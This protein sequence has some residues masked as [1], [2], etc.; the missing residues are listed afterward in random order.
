MSIHPSNF[1]WNDSFARS[2]SSLATPGTVPARVRAEHRGQV[3]VLTEAGAVRAFVRGVLQHGLEA[4]AVGDWVVLRPSDDPAIPPI[5]EA[6]LPRHTRFVRKAAGRRS[7]P[8]VIAANIDTVFV[9]TSMNQELSPRRIERYLAAARAGG[10]QAVVVLTKSDQVDDVAAFVAQVPA[11]HVVAVSALAGDNLD[12]LLPWL[13]P[14]QTVALVGSSGVGKSTL[15]NAL[16][17]EAVQDTGEIR[18]TDDHGRHTTTTRTLLPLPC[19]GCLVDTPGMRELGLWT[20]GDVLD[21][22]FSDIEALAASCAFRD[23]SHT[24]EPGCAVQAAIDEGALDPRRLDSL[25][26]LTREVEH[27]QRRG[28]ARAERQFAREWAKKVQEVQR[29][30]R[31]KR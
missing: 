22:V 28:D 9:T 3:E 6:V 8:Q 21:E 30:Q 29:F 16:L 5:V 13:G 2:F 24:E 4:P 14:G 20:D 10:A 25:R 18:L 23:C 15:V 31:K 1:G 17:G 26:K 27:A 7:E 12:A 19:G 11:E